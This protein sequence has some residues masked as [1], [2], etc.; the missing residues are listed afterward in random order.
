[1]RAS[2]VGSAKLFEL[3]V[4]GEVVA[5]RI[6]FVLGDNLYLY[7]SGYHPRMS[8]YSVMTTCGVRLSRDRREGHCYKLTQ[9]SDRFPARLSLQVGLERCVEVL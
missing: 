9:S 5:S 8:R 4:E 2:E 3:L 1:V 7:F 6:G